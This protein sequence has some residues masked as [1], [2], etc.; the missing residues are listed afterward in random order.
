MEVQGCDLEK[1]ATSHS[2]INI[3]PPREVWD[4]I[5]S[6]RTNWIADARCGPHI[7]FVDPFIAPQHFSLAAQL[8]RAELQNIPPFTIKLEKF[9]YFVFSGSCMLYLEPVTSPPD[10]LEELLNK[11]LKIFPHCDDQIK[12]SKTGKLV[13]HF[14]I[15]RFKNKKE[16]QQNL[17]ILQ[18]SWK[19]VEWIQKEIYFL[20]RVEG[21]PFEISEIIPMGTNITTPYFGLHSALNQPENRES[22]TLVVCGIPKG[23]NTEQLL[24]IMKTGGANPVAA[25]VLLNP[26]GKAR[27]LAVVEFSSK[28]EAEKTL[29]NFKNPHNKVY[30]KPLPVMVFPGVVGSCCSLHPN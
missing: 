15:A 24:E 16:L 19:P 26:D 11:I 29:Q 28:D 20:K 21:D 25:E 13:P 9:N 2:V 23:L 8:L 17:K 4:S 5:Q 7:S 10:A 30:L 27:P 22:W 12:K 14:S 18:E 3:I 6:I 1:L